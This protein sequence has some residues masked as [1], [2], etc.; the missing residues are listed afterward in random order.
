MLGADERLLNLGGILL[1]ETA[2]NVDNLLG[3]AVGLGYLQLFT[4]AHNLGKMS[5]ECDVRTRVGI[6]GL[7]VIPY[8]DNLSITNLG[9]GSGKVETLPGDVLI[10]VDDDVF[11]VQFLAHILLFLQNLGGIVYHILEVHS[12]TLLQ[13]LGVFQVALMTHVQEEFG[14]DVIGHPMHFAELVGIV[15]VGLEVLDE[16]TEQADQFENVLILLRG[17][18]L[19][20]DFLFGTGLHGNAG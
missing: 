9:Q 3:V 10:L 2:G 12:A 7:P 13:F 17:D 8:G 6:D 20:I 11:E 5:E 16:A 18:N 14:A 19:L 4:I 15:A 1:D